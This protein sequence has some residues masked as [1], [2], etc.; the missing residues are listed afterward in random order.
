MH[1]PSYKTCSTPKCPFI[2]ARRRT[3]VAT[4]ADAA[5]K[6]S[7]SLMGM[8]RVLGSHVAIRHR[9]KRC[10][11]LLGNRKLACDRALIY[12]AMT[13]R[14]LHGLA[15]PLIII[16]WS[17]LRADRSQQVLR[18]ALIVQGR[19]LTLYEE[20]HP[21]AK[22]TS[23]KV[24]HTFLLKLKAIMPLHCRPVFVTDAGFRSTWFALL[25]QIGYAWIGRIRN[26]DMVRA[27]GAGQEWHGCKTLYAKATGQAKDLGAF[28]YVRNRPLACRL[29]LIKKKPRGRHHT[30]LQGMR[31]TGS[32]SRKQAKANK[33]PWLLIVSP[34][35]TMSAAAVVAVYSGRMQIEQ[36][37]RDVKN[38]R[39]G[40]GLSDSQTR[41]PG[42]LA[43]LLLIG[44]LACYALW[45]IALAVRTSGYRIEFG[46][47][48]KA[49]QALSLISLAR[50]WI[51]EQG[52]MR[53]SRRQLDQA[54]KLLRSMA[55]VVR[56]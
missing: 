10:D 53:L 32:Q 26:R 43:T 48:K 37:F 36:T 18:A 22:A 52:R 35:L 45:L 9:I 27:C 54:L 13:R 23:L 4:I 5:S 56:I 55:L 38:P 6:G 15:Q 49:A 20:V 34:R 25:D 40:L 44:A 14:L 30:T 17:D 41:Q 21:I 33:E 2:H 39:W 47:K 24:H 7:L 46:S 12:A 31:R 1:S 16:D 19:A 29:V 28:Q 3:C 11:R 8:S 51:A 50:W 42:R